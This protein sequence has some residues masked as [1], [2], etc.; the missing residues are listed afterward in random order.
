[1][2]INQTILRISY[3]KVFFKLRK[4]SHYQSLLRK[5]NFTPVSKITMAVMCYSLSTYLTQ[6]LK[7]TTKKR[8]MPEFNCNKKHYNTKWCQV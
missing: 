6:F 1:M 3:F 8:L 4:K 5:I 7:Y 2:N